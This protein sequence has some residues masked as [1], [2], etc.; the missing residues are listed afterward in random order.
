MDHAP[1]HS[2]PMRSF[3]SSCSR[4][5]VPVLLKA[6]S[7]GLALGLITRLPVEKARSSAMRPSVIHTNDP[8]A[9]LEAEHAK[10]STRANL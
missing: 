1:S 3:P 10:A 4:H 2:T 5:T 7:T 6:K 8:R 9:P